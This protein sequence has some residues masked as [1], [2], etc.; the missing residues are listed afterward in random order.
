[1]GT[2]PAPD[3]LDQ[4]EAV[5]GCGFSRRAFLGGVGATTAS[6]ALLPTAAAATPQDRPSRPTDAV[7]IGGPPN[8]FGRLFPNLETFAED[9][10]Q[11]RDA[12]MDIGRPG[13][14]MDANDDLAAGPVALITDLS[15]SE[16]NRNNPAHTAGTSFVG[17]FI[18]HDLTRD[19][20][21]PL[22]IAV[23]PEDHMNNRA[24]AFDLDSVFSRG[25]VRDRQYYSE[26][27]DGDLITLPIESGGLHEDFARPDGTTAC[28]PEARNDENLV[29]AGVH[30]AIMLFYNKLVD[31]IRAR[32]GPGVDDF[33]VF[34]RARR[35]TR[36]HYQ[37]L[38][39]HEFLPLIVGRRRAEAAFR[40]PSVFGRGP[41][42]MPV[43]FQGAVYRFGH[44][45]V[46]P[47]YRANL[48][49]DDGEPFFGF[50]FD[51]GQI[52]NPDPDDMSGSLR[53][54]RRFI[55]WQTFFDFGDGEVRPNKRIDTVISSPMFNLPPVTIELGPGAQL[56]PTALPQRNLLRHITWSQPSGQAVARTLGVEPLA[57]GDLEDLAA[58]GLG[59]E[60]STPLWFYTL[61][62]AEVVE[63]GLRLGPMGARVVA[64]CFAGFLRS[65]RTSYLSADPGWTPTVGTRTGD[66]RSFDMVDLLTFAEVD[67]A[68]RSARLSGGE[69]PLDGPSAAPVPSDP[70]SAVPSDA[71]SA[72]PSDAPSDVAAASADLRPDESRSLIE[73]I[74]D[75]LGGR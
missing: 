60:T 52:G 69:D 59:L 35:L 34:V 2:E 38:V 37:W 71:M 24:P 4:P 29:V 61:R 73:M 41:V 50:V 66:P 46:R 68:N 74:L 48:D 44:S 70:P 55:G 40:R 42:R 62:E 19:L 18:D 63:D 67:P 25:P 54:P 14:M 1:M 9:S 43:E 51:A 64:D 27:F 49:G 17:Q 10:P 36:W 8:T 58:Y 75:W 28:I 30:L 12:L 32:L 31:Q 11:L 33:D 39:R 72:V 56:G 47:S 13:G 16:R 57:P 21:S 26:R 22:G 3:D 53:G 5:H 65:D 15:L 6:A 23:E 45:M 20:S 7:A